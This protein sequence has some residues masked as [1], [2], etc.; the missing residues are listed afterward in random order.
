MA[1]IANSTDNT[2]SRWGM[3]D[4]LEELFRAPASDIHTPPSQFCYILS[5]PPGGR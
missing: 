5:Q 3:E 2:P 4:H 1:V